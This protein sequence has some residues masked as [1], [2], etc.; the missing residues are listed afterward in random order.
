MYVQTDASDFGLGCVLTEVQDGQE[1]VKGYLIRS[2]TKSEGKYSTVEKENL[3]VLFAV[4]K[5]RPEL[6][7]SN[8]TVM[9]SQYS[10]KW[11]YSIKDPIG[12]I[13]R[14]YIRLQHY[15]REKSM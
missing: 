10:L 12:R 15:D 5:L 1:K 3:T 14:W 8:F 13:D 9:T 7:K 2:L 11:L 6:R 4:E